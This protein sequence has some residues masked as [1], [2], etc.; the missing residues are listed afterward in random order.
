VIL[1]GSNIGIMVVGGAT[2]AAPSAVAL[3]CWPT[4][5]VRLGGSEMRWGIMISLALRRGLAAPKF[6]WPGGISNISRQLRS[7]QVRVQHGLRSPAD[8][9]EFSTG[10]TF[11]PES[12]PAW[13]GCR[14]GR[15]PAMPC[16]ACRGPALRHRHKTPGPAP[17][18]ELRSIPRRIGCHRR[19]TGRPG[20][21]ESL[22]HSATVGEVRLPCILS[23]VTEEEA[24]S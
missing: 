14:G 11:R 24:G 13:Q 21:R 1:I 15:R 9:A 7:T 20:I 22:L 12:L 3:A 8:P 16:R 18:T 2:A 19:K 4:A 5:T 23:R 10:L 17:L 6:K